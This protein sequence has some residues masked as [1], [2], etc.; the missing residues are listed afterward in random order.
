MQLLN[1]CRTS[2]ER[3]ADKLAE[4]GP[5]R[6]A[7]GLPLWLE[8]PPKSVSLIDLGE[9][10]II[11]YGVEPQLLEHLMQ[12]I[13]LCGKCNV[14]FR[15]LR[16]RDPSIRYHGEALVSQLNGSPLPVD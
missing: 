10:V 3:G 6:R 15:Y 14:R 7:R 9:S 1:D 5:I 11:I 12:L 2:W 8:A 16:R 13:K 4:C